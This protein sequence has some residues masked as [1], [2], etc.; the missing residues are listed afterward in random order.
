MTKTELTKKIKALGSISE[1]QKCSVTCSLI[2]H[3]KVVVMCFGYVHCARCGDQIG[4]VLGGAS[5]MTQ[6]VII[7]RHQKDETVCENCL[8]N[9]KKFTWK[10][11]IFMPDEKLK[12]LLEGLG[13]NPAEKKAANRRK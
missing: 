4:D 5:D 12:E 13:L 11:T 7:G 3:S 1:K 10:D 6:R 2:G 9:Y 8:A